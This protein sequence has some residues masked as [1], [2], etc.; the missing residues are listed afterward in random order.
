MQMVGCTGNFSILV[1]RQWWRGIVVYWPS[2]LFVLYR[3]V[4]ARFK[5]QSPLKP[6]CSDISSE[7]TVS[8]RSCPNIQVRY[9]TRN[10]LIRQF[11]LID[12]LWKQV[13]VQFQL[14]DSLRDHSSGQFQLIESTRHQSF[15][16]FQLIDSLSKQFSGQLQLM[17]SLRDHLS[18]QF[19]LIGSTR[20]QLFRQFQL[21]DNLWNQLSR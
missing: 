7:W 21:M 3:V 1:E 14:I 9:I 10:Q 12:S 13:S 17:D 19:Q 20:H 2:L 6:G 15:R 16:Q 5:W 8:E 18:G 4:A 11:Q